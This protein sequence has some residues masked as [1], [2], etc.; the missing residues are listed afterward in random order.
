MAKKYIEVFGS[1][2][3]PFNFYRITHLPPAWESCN[4]CF[5]LWDSS[6]ITSVPTRFPQTHLLYLW[7]WCR[8]CGIPVI[9]IPVHL[10]ILH[11]KI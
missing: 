9:P 7:V 10:S 8:N 2:T 1:F 4:I 3:E 6:Y 11:W 5:G